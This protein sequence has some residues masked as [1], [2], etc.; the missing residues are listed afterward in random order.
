MSETLNLARLKKGSDVFEIVVN[1]EKAIH[2]RSH[3]ETDIREAVVYP[4]IYSDAK[5]GLL[6]PEQR[7]QAVFGTTEPLEAAKQILQKGDIQ[8]TAEYRQK[9]QEQKRNR[10]IDIIRRQGVDPR[11]NAPHPLT[12]IEAALKEAKVRIEEYKPAEQQIADILKALR[13]II[14]IKLVT[15][16]IQ[17]ILPAKYAPKAHSII[18]VFGKVIKERWENDGSWNGQVEIPGGMETEFYDKLNNTTHGQAQ[19]KLINTKGE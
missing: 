18:K 2:Y 17:V 4:K 13:P 14:P 1:P 9:L 10:I 19:T 7:M 5:K 3:P 11:T 6:A 16:E 12:R 15:K 8:V